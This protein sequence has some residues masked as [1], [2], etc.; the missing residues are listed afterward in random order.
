MDEQAIKKTI[1]AALAQHGWSKE[2][3]AAEMGYSLS[4]VTTLLSDK[5]NKR[6]VGSDAYLEAL[7]VLGFEVQIRPAQ[8]AS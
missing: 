7:R 2:K 8:R 6:P 5:P 3:L 1:K 4:T